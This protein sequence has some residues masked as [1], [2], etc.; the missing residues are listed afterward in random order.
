M[1]DAI[2]EVVRMIEEAAGEIAA[3]VGTQYGEYARRAAGQVDG[4]ARMIK[5]K[6]VDSLFA[7]ARGL[8][9]RSPAAA[10]GIAATLG[11]IVARVARAA[12]PGDAPAVR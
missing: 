4:V 5:D 11:F 1:V 2:D 6:D 3:K 12:L 8:V 7:D 9:S 10:I